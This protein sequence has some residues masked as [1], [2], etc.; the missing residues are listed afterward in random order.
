MN[1]NDGRDCRENAP[2]KYVQLPFFSISQKEDKNKR[3]KFFDFG[4]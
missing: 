2:K 4:S 3:D 1:C